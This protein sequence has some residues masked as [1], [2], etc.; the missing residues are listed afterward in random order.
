MNAPHMNVILADQPV[1][2]L[3]RERPSRAA[4][5]ERF[6][7]DYCCRGNTSLA[8]ACRSA[9]VALDDVFQELDASDQSTLARGEE[10]W[11]QKPLAQLI[12]H[13]VRRH[14]SYLRERLP[15]LASMIERVVTAHGKKREELLSVRE[16]FGGLRGELMSH[17]MKEERVLFPFIV[18]ME[19]AAQSGQMVPGFHCGSISSPIAVME[20]EHASAGRAL[21]LLRRITQDFRVPDGAC[22]TYVA[23]LAGLKELEADLH[24]H[25]HLEN[26]ILFPRA[27]ALE[28]CGSSVDAS[29][30][31]NAQ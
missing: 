28:S 8:A 11:S 18:E 21:W 10:D 13:I 12:E 19:H 31:R 22:E 26:N 2:M 14:H 27:A 29:L 15:R 9:G 16:V 20:D 17:M 5:F 23:L 30:L 4:V 7:I 3:V 25:I 24:Q 6:G 1:G